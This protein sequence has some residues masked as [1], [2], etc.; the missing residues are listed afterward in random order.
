MCLDGLNFIFTKHDLL[1]HLPRHDWNED[2]KNS[3]LH[4]YNQ[5]NGLSHL[6][7]LATH[8]PI[9]MKINKSRV[10]GE[11]KKKVNQHSSRSHL[12]GIYRGGKGKRER[13]KIGYDFNLRAGHNKMKSKA[14]DEMKEKQKALLSLYPQLN[15]SLSFLNDCGLLLSLHTSFHTKIEWDFTVPFGMHGPHPPQHCFFFSFF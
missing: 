11:E 14:N 2:Y 8:P 1:I 10:K 15:I 4:D 9:K 7:G 6:W 13:K 5:D 12:Q 3:R